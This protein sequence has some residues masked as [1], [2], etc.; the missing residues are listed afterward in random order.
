VILMWLKSLADVMTAE[1]ALQQ[2]IPEIELVESAVILSRAKRMGWMLN[3]DST[4]TGAVVVADTGVPP[5][6][7]G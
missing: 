5:L 6:A 1:L 3:P 2:R 7:L 4:A